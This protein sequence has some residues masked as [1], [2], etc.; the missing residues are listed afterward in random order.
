MDNRA[1]ILEKLLK[2]TE[3]KDWREPSKMPSGECRDVTTHLAG[4]FL[5][6]HIGAI[7]EALR[8]AD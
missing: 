3:R 5:K 1:T 6:T 7:M 2:L 4:I 8:R